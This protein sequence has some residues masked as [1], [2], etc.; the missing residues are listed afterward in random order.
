M[1]IYK[2]TPIIDMSKCYII[3][4]RLRNAWEHRPY[5]MSIL[6]FEKD[7]LVEY[8]KYNEVPID[9]ATEELMATGKPST[10][11]F[12]VHK[13]IYNKNIIF[14]YP[15]Y[16]EIELE[17][18]LKLKIKTLISNYRHRCKNSRDLG[19][20]AIIETDDLKDIGKYLMLQELLT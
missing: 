15:I 6:S 17:E 12:N 16:T 3:Y 14:N 11:Y 1:R 20:F 7:F 8:V 18:Y 10:H 9:K 13:H 2:D 19:E 5:M 4:G